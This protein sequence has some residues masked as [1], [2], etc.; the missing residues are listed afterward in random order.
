MRE[1][2]TKLLHQVVRH[3]VA[4]AKSSGGPK[5]AAVLEGMRQTLAA[6]SVLLQVAVPRRLSQAGRED[7]HPLYAMSTPPPPASGAVVLAG[8]DLARALM[9]LLGDTCP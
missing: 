9:L 4:K 6:P 1:E 3:H 5:D 7:R 2:G 8:L